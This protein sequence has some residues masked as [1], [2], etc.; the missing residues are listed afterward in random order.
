[1]KKIYIV[2]NITENGKNYAFVDTIRAGE[3]LLVHIERHKNCNI[4][5]LCETRKQ[6]EFL[7]IHW[8]ACYKANGTYLF[9]YPLF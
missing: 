2:F 5:H 6:A 9:D 1:M 4:C 8:N 3:N 7:A